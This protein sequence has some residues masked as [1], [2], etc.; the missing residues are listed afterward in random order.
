MSDDVRSTFYYYFT[1]EGLCHS[2]EY[3]SG[4]EVPVAI[5]VD[6]PDGSGTETAKR[7]GVSDAEAKA[8]IEGAGAGVVGVGSHWEIDSDALGVFP[9]QVKEMEAHC[10]K[11]GVPTEFDKRTGRAKLKDQ[12][13]R[14]KLCRLRKAPDLDGGF[15]DYTGK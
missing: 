1:K 13:H 12:A 2:K 15:R 10:A 5:T 6:T 4:E 14:A 8:A 9:S 7:K 11:H 3:W